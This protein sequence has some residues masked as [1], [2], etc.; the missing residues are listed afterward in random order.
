MDLEYHVA[1]L[2]WRSLSTERKPCWMYNG[3]VL[4]KEIRLVRG[5]MSTYFY[6]ACLNVILLL[7]YVDFYWCIMLWMIWNKMLC[8]DIRTHIS[9]GKMRCNICFVSWFIVLIWYD[10][11]EL[12]PLVSSSLMRMRNVKERHMLVAIL[13]TARQRRQKK[14]LLQESRTLHC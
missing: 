8:L 13:W 9:M 10:N 11:F 5:T 6:V 12:T 1:R 2:L 3:T 14:K 4:P 7:E